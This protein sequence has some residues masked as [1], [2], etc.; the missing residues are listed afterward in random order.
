MAEEKHFRKVW[1]T[2]CWESFEVP[3]GAIE[4]I[5]PITCPECG[6]TDIVTGHIVHGLVYCNDCYSFGCDASVCRCDCHKEEIGVRE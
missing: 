6:H 1:C 5:R 4:T 3:A 2:G